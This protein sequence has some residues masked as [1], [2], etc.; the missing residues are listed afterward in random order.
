VD[1]LE[2]MMQAGMS[3]VRMNFSH[4]SYEVCLCN[5]MM[6]I[7]TLIVIVSVVI[8]VADSEPGSGEASSEPR[9]KIFRLILGVAEVLCWHDVFYMFQLYM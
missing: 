5:D 8:V 4:G 2:K 6:M 1:V 9:P 3:I 7:K